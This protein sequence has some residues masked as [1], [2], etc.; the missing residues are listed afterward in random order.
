MEQSTQVQLL[1]RHYGKG[2]VTDI[3]S[4][5]FSQKRNVLLDQPNI[6][7]KT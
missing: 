1:G 7:L 4:S 2:P 3:F 6:P 5:V